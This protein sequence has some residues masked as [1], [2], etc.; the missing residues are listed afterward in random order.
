MRIG[1]LG[2][3]DVGRTLARGLANRG[4]EAKLGTRDPQAEKIQTWL[5]GTKGNA[6]AGTFGEAAEF[7]EMLVLATRWDGTE[8]AIRLA[9]QA[10][11]A[12]KVVLDTTNPL[13]FSRGVPPTLSVAGNDSAG[14][15]VQRWLPDARVV[16]VFN[17]VGNA[18]M[19]DPDFSDGPPDL[20]ICG[21][22][23]AAKQTA[24]EL[25][26]SLGWSGAIDLGGILHARYLEPMAMVWIVHGFNIKSWNHAFKLL[27]K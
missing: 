18:H 6:S 1:V 3:G 20:Y 8:N 10:A 22:D 26:K 19:V 27:R 23:P 14:E 2:S 17:T 25:A 24:I 15:Q 5:A 9:G 12:G 7:G 16:K 4:N 13:D 11:F 21:D